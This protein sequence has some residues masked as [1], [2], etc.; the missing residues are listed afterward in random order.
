MKDQIKYK[1]NI[2]DYVTT[3]LMIICFPLNPF[4]LLKI[5]EPKGNDILTIFGI[6]FWT[7]GM[8]FVIYPFIYFKSKGGVAKGKSY[9]HTN[10]IV[11]TGLYSI[12]RH[13]QYTGGILSIFIATPLLYPHW[14]LI[15]LGIAGIVFMYISIKKEDKLLIEKF[16]DEY[17]EYI[18][19]VPAVN[20]I[21]GIYRKIKG[22]KTK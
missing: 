18:A 4:V 1:P 17:K 20:F 21:A 15:V 14:T 13:V 7:L 19:K 22:Q 16:G 9:V 5:I 8:V 11:T 12:L 3:L 10:K 2:L 6:I